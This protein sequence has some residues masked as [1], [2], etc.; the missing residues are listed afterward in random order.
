[1]AHINVENATIEFPVYGSERSFRKFLFKNTI[2]GRIGHDTNDR[3]KITAIKNASFDIGPGDRV[4]L[5]GQNGAGKSTLLKALAGIYEPVYGRIEVEGQVSA[6]FGTGLGIDGDDTGYRNIEICGLVLGMSEAEI[7]RKTDDIAAFTELGE[8]LSLPVRTY[9]VGMQMRLTFAIA[10]AIEPEILLMDETIGAGDAKFQ[11]KA[12]NRVGELMKRASILVLA[13]HSN[14]I[15]RQYCS[16]AIL[17]Y[18]GEIIMFG[19]V[20]DVI[21][22]Y[23]EFVANE[24]I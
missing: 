22:K 24:D 13:S 1:M 3:V 7:A 19:D 6:I 16:K 2:G 8:Y 9:S 14:E 4:G 17:L 11:T 5:I 18:F 12:I 15:V 21:A 10:T 20:E 23:E